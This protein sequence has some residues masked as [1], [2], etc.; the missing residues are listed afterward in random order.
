[1][2]KSTKMWISDAFGEECPI[3]EV[4]TAPNFSLTEVLVNNVR[5]RQYWQVPGILQLLARYQIEEGSGDG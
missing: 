2:P 5:R 1:M 3:E 4:M